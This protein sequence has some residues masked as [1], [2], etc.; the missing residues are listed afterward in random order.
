MA[1]LVAAVAS[2][3]DRAADELFAFHMVQHLLLGLVAPLLIVAAAP[4]QVGIF[5]LSA[6]SRRTLL[7]AGHR[8]SAVTGLSRA[9]TGFALAAVVAHVGLMFLWHV[10]PVYDL[11]VRHPLLHG[12]EHLTLFAAGVALWWVVLS[13]GWH[14]RSAMAVVYLFLAGLPLGAL[15]AIFTLAP[16]PLYA[17]HL[18][19]SAAWG[20][21]PLED[22][23]LA[24]AIMWVPGGGVYL[25]MGTALFVR[26]LGAGPL[27]GERTA[28]WDA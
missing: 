25:A 5:G 15:A 13:V 19:T 20:L 12:G 21:T 6:A 2:P 11:A 4:V 16:H 22:Q 23:Q 10:P 8:S 3:L 26:W 27:P 9:S 14:H 28:A 7:R 18:A 17:S 1:V 24:G